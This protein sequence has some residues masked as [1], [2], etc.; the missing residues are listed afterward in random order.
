MTNIS[1][2]WCTTTRRLNLFFYL[3]WNRSRSSWD[4]IYRTLDERQSRISHYCRRRGSP[5]SQWFCPE[6]VRSSVFCLS[7]KKSIV[8]T[9]IDI[10]RTNRQKKKKIHKTWTEITQWLRFRVRSLST[11]PAWSDS[12]NG[13]YVSTDIC[14]CFQNDN[15]L[16]LSSSLK[17]VIA[18]TRCELV[19]SR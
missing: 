6:F 4:R 5:R 9:S 1:G 15:T 12:Q 19:I 11:W 18:Y 17:Y 7:E 13:S 3:R 10:T 8:F 14:E 16:G 2:R